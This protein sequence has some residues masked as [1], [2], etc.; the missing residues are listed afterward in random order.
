MNNE[1]LEAGLR[2]VVGESNV[3]AGP[4]GGPALVVRPGTTKAVAECLKL[5]HGQQAPVV[6]LG[7][8]TGLVHGTH[9]PSHYFGISTERLNRIES[10]DPSTRL[11]VVGAGTK[12]EA[13]HDF[14]ADHDLRY[15]VDLGARGSCTIGGNIATN[16]G[17]NSVIRFGM[18]RSNVVGLEAVLSD[19]S[20]V[21]DLRGLPKN[22]A[23]YDLKQIFIGSEGTLGVVTKALL[24]LSRR[25]AGTASVLLA[26]DHLNSALTVMEALERACGHSLLALEIMWNRYFEKVSTALS[27]ETP[28]LPPGHPVYLL[29]QVEGM[30]SGEQAVDSL[31]GALVG[32]DDIIDSALATTPVQESRLWSIRDGSDVIE[33]AHEHVLS[34]DVSMRPH[35][36]AAYIADV[37]ARLKARI[38]DAVAYY[39]GHLADGNIHFMIGHDGSLSDAT[40]LIEECVYDALASYE[41]SSISAEHGIGREKAAHLWRSRS[42]AEIAAMNRIRAALD[43]AGILN[44]HISYEPKSLDAQYASAR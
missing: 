12:L 11:V 40:R 35:K 16:A 41:P 34:F 4:P 27:E 14:A 39:F 44:P 17:G 33:R 28:P 43:P 26:L 24:K 38:S 31:V 13:V 22:N 5:F 9:T 23:G 42:T 30:D 32:I 15:G 8:L 25:P 20:I 19:G 29:A 2:Q 10:F 1:T 6:T 21:T 37:E 7:G 36:Y 18:T 3:I